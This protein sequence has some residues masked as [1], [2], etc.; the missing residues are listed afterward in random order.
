MALTLDEINAATREYYL[1][2]G[3]VD[4][5]YKSNV[6]VFRLMNNKRTID[7]GKAI[8]VPI[9]HGSP[10]GGAF[11]VNDTFDTTRRDQINAAEYQWKYYYEPTTYDL[12]D[13]TENNGVSAEVDIVLTKVEMMNKAI[14]EKI[15][16]DLYTDNSSNTKKVT[17]LQEMLNSTTTTAYGGIQEADLAV[18]T[19]GAVTT[20]TE[21]LTLSAMRTMRTN[22]K[23]GDSAGDIPSLY[24]TTDILRDKYESLL[25][26]QQRF[27]DPDMAKAG[28]RTLMFGDAGVVSDGKCPSGFM[29]A[30]NENYMQWVSHSDFDMQR[31]EWMRPTNQYKYTTQVINA[32]N[33]TCSRRE[34]HVSHSNL[35]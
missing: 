15:G 20:T 31:S 3:A 22:A 6:L 17:G 12:K 7:G 2:S 29:F 23:V 25:Q 21:A 16:T 4:N 18:W 32:G 1:T 24:I 34:A 35:S 30:L 10:Q 8:R 9:W 5:F 14:M 28:F 13:A 27:E 33:L 26:P 19:P 11:G